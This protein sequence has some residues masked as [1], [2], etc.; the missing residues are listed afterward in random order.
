MAAAPNRTTSRMRLERARYWRCQGYLLRQILDKL[1]AEGLGRMSEPALSTL[2]KRHDDRVLA[3]L[4]EIKR[5]ERINQI[6]RLTHTY[7]EA[8]QAWHASKESAKLLRQKVVEGDGD[9][10]EPAEGMPPPPRRRDRIEKTQEL[11]ERD[12][13][14]AY[15]TVAL[16]ALEQIRKLLGLDAPAENINYN[17]A[18]EAS[19]SLRAK[20]QALHTRVF[21]EEANGHANGHQPTN[22]RR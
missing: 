20:I 14:T 13:E 7:V 5:Q 3:S 18:V 22:G 19:A 2:L 1:E 17:H 12:G 4:D 6:E 10:P 15:L 21:P 16:K 11:R 8:M 9:L